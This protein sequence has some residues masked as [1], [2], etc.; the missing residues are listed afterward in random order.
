ML[1]VL[2]V[3]L[4][5]QNPA[6]PPATVPDVGTLTL[7]APRVALEIDAGKLQG[8]PARLAWGPEG[9]MYLR[10]SQIDRWANERSKHYQ[11]VLPAA[12]SA[13]SA[14]R[15]GSLEG[16]PA[17]A[18][19][20]W[21]WKSA[22]FAP[23][24]P[25]LKFDVDVQVG[26]KTATASLRDQGL[27]Q[28]G[29]DPSR[30]RIQSDVESAQQVRTTTVKLKGQ[31]IAE[32]VN[33]SFV[34]GFTFGWAPSPM[35]ILAYVDAKKRLTLVDREGRTREVPGATD[36]LL[37]AWSPDGRQ[38]AYLAKKDKKKYDLMIVDVVVGR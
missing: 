23:G 26:L 30:P 29:G 35:G 32:L 3:S 11:L 16:E 8:D 5:A 12:S 4:L 13:A 31:V 18:S 6:T 37:P 14:P 25:D 7:S 10:V 38:I 28:S 21:L 22:S 20:Y 9:A 19:S 33:Q 36:A 1:I 24:N 34:P 17:W 2:L 15:T 27:S